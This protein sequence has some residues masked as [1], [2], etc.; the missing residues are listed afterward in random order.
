[1]M[2]T[3]KTHTENNNTLPHQ[4]DHRAIYML[5]AAIACGYVYQGPPF[6]LSYRGLGEPLCFLAFGP[7]ATT[8]FFLAQVHAPVVAPI[9]LV[10]WAT[11]ALVGVTTSVIL[12]CSHFHQIEGDRAAGKW[13]PLVRLG[14]QTAAEVCDVGV[15]ERGWMMVDATDMGMKRM[16]ASSQVLRLVCVATYCAVA[17]LVHW[18]V[19]PQQVMATMVL[20][21]PMALSMVWQAHNHHHVPAL[22]RTLK[23]RAIRWHVAVGAALVAGLLRARFSG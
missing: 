1:M 14:H 17:A 8:S 2:Q 6:R 3:T 9:P 22:V 18:Q 20:T 12:F 23:F 10:V 16:P 5:A 4:G 15:C 11:G 21:L 7:L 19:L 13:S